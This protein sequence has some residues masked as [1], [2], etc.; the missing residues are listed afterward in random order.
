M[1]QVRYRSYLPWV[2]NDKIHAK[3]LA[4]KTDQKEKQENKKKGLECF[5]KSNSILYYYTSNGRAVF[6]IKLTLLVMCIPESCI[7]IKINLK[8]EIKI[9][10]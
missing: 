2:T 10:S 9:L 3:K 4:N 8:C 1:R 5:L 7:E 6:S